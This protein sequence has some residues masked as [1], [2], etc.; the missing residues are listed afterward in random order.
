MN[1]K[2]FITF[3]SKKTNYDVEPGYPYEIT[4]RLFYAQLNE[5]EWQLSYE[6]CEEF[7]REYL[8]Q[9]YKLK[10]IV[11]GGPSMF[12]N[13]LVGKHINTGEYSIIETTFF[14]MEN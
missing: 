1:K 8:E 12:Y 7:A 10:G 11:I 4:I 2:D 14:K 3:E 13:N 5:E 6:E 9:K